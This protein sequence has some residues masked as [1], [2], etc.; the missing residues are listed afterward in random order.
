MGRVGIEHGTDVG[1]GLRQAGATGVGRGQRVAAAT[2]ILMA[3]YHLSPVQARRLLARAG[4]HTHRSLR[5]VADTVLHTGAL[6]GHHGRPVDQL[7]LPTP[8]NE[9]E[10]AEMP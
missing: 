10:P 7:L 9:P 2:G 4:D 3:L 8:A 6:P 1:P 5:E